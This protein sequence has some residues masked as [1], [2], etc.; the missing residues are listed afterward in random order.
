MSPFIDNSGLLRV[1]GRL[2]HYSHDGSK[3]F[4]LLLPANHRFIDLLIHYIHIKYC[5]AGHT[6][7]H[8]LIND[9]YWI[10]NAKT[11]IRKVLSKC[12]TCFKTRLLALQPKMGDLPSFRVTPNTKPFLTVGVD[13]AGPFNITMSRVRGSKRLKAYICIFICLTTKAIH[14]ELVSDLSADTFLAALRRY[15]AR[16]GR[17]N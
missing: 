4:P 9:R 5:H 6:T 12:K 7:V 2:R 17:C 13:Y 14:T 10:L 3:K 8:N 11:V 1:G 15:M 16:R